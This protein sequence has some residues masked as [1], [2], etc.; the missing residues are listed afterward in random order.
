MICVRSSENED[1]AKDYNE[2]MQHVYRQ[3]RINFERKL[4]LS[5]CDDERESNTG[6]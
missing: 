4:K 6:N 2:W 3:V 5:N 1:P